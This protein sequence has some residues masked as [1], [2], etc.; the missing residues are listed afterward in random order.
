MSRVFSKQK[1]KAISEVEYHYENCIIRTSNKVEVEKVIINENQKCFKLASSSLLFSSDI[2]NQIRQFGY[3]Q[4]TR[5]LIYKGIPISTNNPKLMK[6]LQ[7]LYQ[8]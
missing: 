7:L 1:L 6:F 4:G 2:L 8:P 5:D 3:N